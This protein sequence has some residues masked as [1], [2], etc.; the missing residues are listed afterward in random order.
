[1]TMMTLKY[2]TRL[3][4]TLVFMSA[5]FAVACAVVEFCR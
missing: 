3:I 4:W 1:M 2:M 5:V